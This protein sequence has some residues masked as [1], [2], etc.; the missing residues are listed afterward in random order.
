MLP[1]LLVLLAVQPQAPSASALIKADAAT[2]AR[3]LLI[4]V[5]LPWQWSMAE[6]H[7]RRLT[8]RGQ[9]RRAME[10]AADLRR[11][12]TGTDPGQHVPV[13]GQRGR[14]DDAGR[15]EQVEQE[16]AAAGR[17]DRAD[18]LGLASAGGWLGCTGRFGRGSRLGYWSWLGYRSR[19]RIADRFGYGS[20]LGLA[21]RFGRGGRF[22][23]ASRFRLADRPRA[24]RPV[25]RAGLLRHDGRFRG[26]A[27]RLSVVHAPDR[28]VAAALAFGLGQGTGDLLAGGGQR[29]AIVVHHRPGLA[30][31]LVVAAHASLPPVLAKVVSSR[32][33]R[34]EPLCGN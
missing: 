31:V 34:N 27:T 33:N 6:V 21:D 23:C 9:Q 24:S 5:F 15:G 11:A 16:P 28:H 19:L 3:H 1:M 13:G 17:R 8:Q 10:N 7:D 25:D 20:R 18:R 32:A 29:H 22:R 14:D 4:N 30:T 12:G 26:T 2:G